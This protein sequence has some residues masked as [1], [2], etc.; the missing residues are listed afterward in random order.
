MLLTHYC[1]G[2]EIETNG[3]DGAR[4]SDGEGRGVYRGLVEKPEG[5]RP[6]GRPSVDGRIII[7]WIFRKWDLG[8]WTG[9]SWL[10][11]ETGGGQL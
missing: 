3:M 4:R 5:K 10:R 2:D 8:V 11:I 7:R 1:A 9:L 6:M